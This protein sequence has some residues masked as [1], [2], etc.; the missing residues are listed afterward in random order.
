MKIVLQCR[1]ASPL[2]FSSLLW[3]S[4]YDAASLLVIF[5]GFDP[6]MRLSHFVVGSRLA[7]LSPPLACCLVIL[8]A[9]FVQFASERVGRDVER[10]IV[11]AFLQPLRSRG[12]K[13]GFQP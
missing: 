3:R 1:M 10:K 5:P 12:Q 13:L 4:W 7:Y 2:A 6:R 9:C 8:Y 11:F